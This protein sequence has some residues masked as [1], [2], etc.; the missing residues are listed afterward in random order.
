MDFGGGGGGGKELDFRWGGDIPGH[1][2]L[3]WN[4]CIVF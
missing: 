3:V 1:C 4:T 2:T